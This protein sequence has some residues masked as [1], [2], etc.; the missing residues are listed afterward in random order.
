M[1]PFDGIPSFEARALAAIERELVFASKAERSQAD[2]AEHLG[3][4][5]QRVSQYEKSALKKMRKGASEV[6]AEDTGPTLHRS[7]GSIFATNGQKD[8]GLR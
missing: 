6:W 5:Q 2:V 3:I 7:L 1:T 4:S 8:T